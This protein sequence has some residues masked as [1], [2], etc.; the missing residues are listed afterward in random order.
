LLDDIIAGATYVTTQADGAT[1]YIQRASGRKRTFHIV[2]ES[3]QGV[4][5]GMLDLTRHELNALG[6][7]YGF[8]LHF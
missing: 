1:V 6:R 5:T 3:E 4:V 7:N 2:I 8:E